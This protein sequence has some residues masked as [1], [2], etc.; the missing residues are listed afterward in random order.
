[1]ASER[2]RQVESLY[3]AA[4]ERSPEQRAAYLRE[5]CGTDETLRRELEALLG[6]DQH[7]IDL[8]ESPLAL[9]G[10]DLASDAAP[11]AVRTGQRVG[12][13]VIAD[14]LGAGG[15]GEVF[16]AHDTKLRRDVAIKILPSEFVAD[17]ERLVRFEREARHL[18][19]LNHPNIGAI[20]GLES[21][22]G[23][24]A[25]VLE[26]VPGDTLAERIAEGPIPVSDAL[27]C[28][29][30]IAAGLD[31]AHEKGLIH[32]DLKP[33]NVKI[34]PEGVVKILDF[35]LARSAGPV[36]PE[37]TAAP[38]ATLDHTREGTVIGTAAYMSPEQTQ[39]HAVDVRTDFGRLAPC[40]TRCSPDGERSVATAWPRRLLRYC[41]T[42]RT[43]ARCPP[44]RR[45]PCG[46]CS[47]AAWTSPFADASRIW[48][49][50]TWRS[51][52]RRT[53]GRILR[54]AGT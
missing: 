24:P 19:S 21:L 8:V 9:S 50:S 6:A 42:T 25:L 14:R 32:R 1:M 31:A 51:P 11:A 20:H 54:R 48:R 3:R 39:G 2:E 17:R 26:L 49:P 38:T 34:T 13:Y 45:P 41:V 28:A 27:K 29:H 22:D 46:A 36:P 5:V 44:T 7:A 30:Q 12:P 10:P 37:G 53:S 18:A 52:R 23:A 43:G 47:R 15:M 35:G 40:C 4:L 33:A 16:R